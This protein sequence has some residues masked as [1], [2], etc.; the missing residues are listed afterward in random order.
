MEEVEVELEMVCGVVWCTIVSLYVVCWMLNVLCYVFSLCVFFFCVSGACFACV[1]IF[2]T[3]TVCLC[4]CEIHVFVSYYYT[5]VSKR[6][7][8]ALVY[9]FLCVFSSFILNRLSFHYI[10]ISLHCFW[11]ICLSTHHTD[12][13]FQLYVRVT[14]WNI[15]N[16]ERQLT[17]TI[18]L[19]MST[20]KISNQIRS[21]V[22]FG[23]VNFW[24]RITFQ[25]VMWTERIERGQ[26]GI[27]E[28]KIG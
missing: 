2:A 11:V 4:V 10:R 15:F 27:E 16:M 7:S 8:A 23:V 3:E 22:V 17:E 25:V 24:T 13:L 26:Q 9:F 19:R 6:I 28:K 20:W 5:T 21:W 12:L 14:N 1:C 18:H